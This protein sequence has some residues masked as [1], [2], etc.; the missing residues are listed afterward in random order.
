[1][2]EALRKE[3]SGFI[4]EKATEIGFSACGI[5]RARLLEEPFAKLLE[6]L[7]AGKHAT[8]AYLER[9]PEKRMDPTIL[10]EGAKS[11]ISFLYKY[12]PSQ[13]FVTVNNY[14]I[15]RFALGADYHVV[16]KQKMEELVAEISAKF[17]PFKYR[18]FT[19]S[20]PVAE[21]SWAALSGLGWIGKNS[22]LINRTLGSFTFICEI[23]CDLDL[24]PDEE[25]YSGSCGNCTKCIESCPTSAISEGG[26]VDARKCISYHTIETRD[27]IPAQI[28][29]FATDIIY[30]CD[31][32]QDV[33]PFNKGI[34]YQPNNW[35]EPK[36]YFAEMS[37]EDWEQL[38]EEKFDILF[39]T[40]GIKRLTYAGFMNKIRSYQ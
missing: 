14:K 34:E 38:S 3:I 11:V 24:I 31:I 25:V 2:S 15:A 5:S 7:Q 8:M 23:I 21:K 30:G 1:M 9:D 39:S 29:L 13:E 4:K 22:L 10:V 32:C 16:L 36:T 6:W 19:D 27:A 18:V 26:K 37:K 33:C 40:S 20:A 12:K 17:G 35:L 28:L